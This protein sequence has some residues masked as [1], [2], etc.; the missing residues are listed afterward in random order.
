M[1]E[2]MNEW[3]SFHFFLFSGDDAR[4][5]NWL[6]TLRSLSKGI[7]LYIPMY[8]FLRLK[9]KKMCFRRKPGKEGD[10]VSECFCECHRD[11]EYRSVCIR[12]ARWFIFKPKI[13]FWVNFGGSC[14]WRC[15]YILYTFGPF[16]GHLAYFIA[17][18]YI[19]PRHGTFLELRYLVDRQL[20]DRQV[21]ERHLVEF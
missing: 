14:N 18:W 1:S 2:R 4:G 11:L 19:F 16:P 3:H 17:I 13:P 7:G 10:A 6:S 12:V 5:K 9:C 20:V 21:V 8:N 15:W